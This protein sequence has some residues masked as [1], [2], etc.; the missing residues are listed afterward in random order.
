ML[1]LA[2]LLACSAL[3]LLP[4]VSFSQNLLSNPESVVFDSTQNR[5][6]V[7]NW[8][9]GTIVQ[10]DKNGE[11]SY[12]NTDLQGDH[13]L[14][15]LHI[16]DG[17]LY[18][19]VA[20]GPNKG[21]VRFDLATQAMISNLGV[22]ELEFANGLTSDTSGILYITDFSDN[23][24][25]QARLSDDSSSVLVNSGLSTPNGILFDAPNNRLLVIC[26]TGPGA[27]ILSVSLPD[28]D[29]QELVQTH[30]GGDGLTQDNEGNTY[31]SSWATDRTYRYDINFN[32]PVVFSEGHNNPAD[33][34]YNRL[35]GLLAIP[36]F[37]GNSVDLVFDPDVDLDGDSILSSLDNCFLEYNPEQE[38]SDSDAVGDS[39]DNCID[40]PNPKQGDADGDGIGDMCEID[41]DDDGIL[42]ED[43]NCWLVQNPDQINSDT[44]SLGDACDNCDFVYNPYQ[45]DDDDDGE[46]DACESEGLFIQCC[47]DM[48]QVYL[49][50]PYS[51]QFW[52]VGGT[53]PYTWSKISGQL[54]DG[55]TLSADGILSGVPGYE[56]T[57][58]FYVQLRDQDYTYDYQW[59]TMT[60]DILPPPLY[61]CG[62]G[63]GS[64]SVD[65]D[66]VVYLIQYIFA[67]G[68]APAPLEAGDAD[69]SGGIDIDDVVYLINY[70]FAGG[71]EP[72]A[73]C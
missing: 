22:L 20:Q 15:G 71:S 16:V 65:I 29:L 21:V 46:G 39:C 38:D 44:D 63:D 56:E 35:H 45:Y 3:L 67:G 32:P 57:Y 25:F 73:D 70:I 55:L 61:I 36:N 27:P 43:D 58:T 37:D 41:A 47:L 50:E 5:Y 24:I 60:V 31:I 14:A 2:I 26:A 59:I 42:N 12:F 17:F 66:D 7:S 28:G 11:Q 4:T 69:C 30:V 18:A 51:Y 52:G 8:G 72:C 62:D 40:T 23:K 54:P 64:E 48:P 49:D 19:A 33:I 6:L 10:I 1:R 13:N 68:S 34:F 9:D 53:P